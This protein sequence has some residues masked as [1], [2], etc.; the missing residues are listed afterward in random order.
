MNMTT[1]P[2]IGGRV[3]GAAALALLTLGG[4]VAAQNGPSGPHRV[5]IELKDF[6]FTPSSVTVAPGDTLV[7]RQTTDTPHNIQFVKSPKGAKFGSSYVPPTA[8]AAKD[9][10]AGH[11]TLAASAPTTTPT[12]PP[13]MGPFLLHKG[14]EYVIVIGP[15]FPPGEYDYECTPHQ[16]FG[17]K[18]KFIVKSNASS[19]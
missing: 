5:V 15:Y 10:S 2:E 8:A 9:G 7:F 6:S 18:G 17:M 19:S 11:T 14:Q 16:S 3:L 12:A 13:R 1:S 4:P